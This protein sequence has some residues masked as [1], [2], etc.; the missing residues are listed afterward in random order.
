MIIGGILVYGVRM[1][2]ASFKGAPP[3]LTDSEVNLGKRLRNYVYILAMEIGEG[4]WPCHETLDRGKTYI[5]G[6]FKQMDLNCTS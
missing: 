1:P 2:G 4:N 6:Q 3:P 5:E